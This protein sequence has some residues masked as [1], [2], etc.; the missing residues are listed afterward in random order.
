MS[1]V[2]VLPGPTLD[3][4]LAALLGERVIYV[5]PAPLV[6]V[7]ELTFTVSRSGRIASVASSLLQWA[8]A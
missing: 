3:D 5:T 1:G 2:V 4:G 8:V 6:D 7:A